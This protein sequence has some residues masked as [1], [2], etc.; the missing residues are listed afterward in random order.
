MKGQKKYERIKMR[1]REPNS[2]EV[3]SCRSNVK[4]SCS[5]N[6]KGDYGIFFSCPFIFHAAIKH[7]YLQKCVHSCMCMSLAVLHVLSGFSLWAF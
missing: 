5:D 3:C 7:D 4:S 2:S 1:G 6:I